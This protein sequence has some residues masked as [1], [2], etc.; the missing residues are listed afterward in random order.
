MVPYIFIIVHMRNCPHSKLKSGNLV[1]AGYP[2]VIP[3]K[4]AAVFQMEFVFAE[5]LAVG[6]KFSIWL[7]VGSD[8]PAFS[9]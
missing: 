8:G 6:F 1:E 5:S 9:L 7:S 3:H 2:H 4:T